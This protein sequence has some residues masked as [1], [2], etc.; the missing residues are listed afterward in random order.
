MG[1]IVSGQAEETGVPW[2]IGYIHIP[3]LLGIVVI[4]M[5]TAPLGARLAHSLPV[6]ALKRV[7]ASLLFALSFY[8]FYRAFQGFIASSQL[9]GAPAHA[10]G[11]AN[12]N[13]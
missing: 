13:N 10:A 8:M 11:G 5:L 4:S 7:F 12:P 9:G 3:T 1:Y 2:M 6:A